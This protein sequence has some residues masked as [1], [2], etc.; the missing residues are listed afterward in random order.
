MHIIKSINNLR[1]ALMRNVTRRLGTTHIEPNGS[2]VTIGKILVCR[3]NHRLGNLLLITPLLQ[4]IENT[5]PQAKVD[6]FVKGSV[7]PE[8]F[9]NYGNL[10][11]IILLPKKPQKDILAYLKSW[12]AIRSN[13]YDLV[14]NAINSSSSGKISSQ[15]ANGRFKFLGEINDEIKRGNADHVHMAK[16]P[17]YSFRYFIKL[18]GFSTTDRRVPALDLKLTKDEVAKGRQ[19]LREV[20]KSDKPVI[21][22]YTYATGQKC[23]PPGWW[24]EL[25]A[26]LKER[27]PEHNILEVLPIEN[28]SQIS[29]KA[30]AFYSRDLRQIASLL[31]NVSIFIGADSGMMHLASAAH[32][33]VIGLFKSENMNQYAPYNDRSAGVRTDRVSQPEIVDMVENRMK[34]VLKTKPPFTKHDQKC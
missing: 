21:A 14:I 24:N 19:L 32:V 33:P 9:R 30:P 34:F 8:L 23:Y 3:P 1:R 29:F 6:L 26:L 15:L 22:I 12:M 10:N 11:R 2:A 18:L 25:Y 31:C 20:L 16:I 5:L 27:F 4:E 13:H 7:A 17:V 28:V